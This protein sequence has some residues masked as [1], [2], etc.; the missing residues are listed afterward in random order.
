M[1]P[2]SCIKAR[3]IR[4]NKTC[5]QIQYLFNIIRGNNTRA[6]RVQSANPTGHP[7]LSGQPRPTGVSICKAHHLESTVTYAP[8]LAS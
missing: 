1:S 5:Y 7:L 4:H 2:G 3:L 8:L 6:S